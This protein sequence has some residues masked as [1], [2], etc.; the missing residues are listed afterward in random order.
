MPTPPRHRWF[1]FSLQALLGAVALAS[2]ALVLIRWSNHPGEYLAGATEWELW[3]VAKMFT[4]P[5]ICGLIG[6]AIGLLVNRPWI[7]ALIGMAISSVALPF[8]VLSWLP[9]VRV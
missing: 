3:F 9:G 5:V 8:L 1:Q 7:G 6:G 4:F 2:C